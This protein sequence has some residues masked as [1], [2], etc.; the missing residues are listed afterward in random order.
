M[1]TTPTMA[2]TTATDGHRSLIKYH[3]HTAQRDVPRLR[4]KRG[5]RLCH[6]YSDR[7][8]DELLAWG[9]ERGLKPQ[10]VDRRNVLP[11]YDVLGASVAEHEPGVSRAE[12]VADIRWW[13][14]YQNG[15]DRVR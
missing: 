6:V 10:W 8:L 4:A 13:R 1:P 12:L 2:G 15:G 14:D 9:A 7:S 5:D 3:F 11:H